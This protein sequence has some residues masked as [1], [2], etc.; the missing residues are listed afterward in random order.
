MWVRLVSFIVLGAET[1]GSEPEE[2][3]EA[4]RSLISRGLIPLGRLERFGKQQ[5][6]GKA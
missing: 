6:G 3:K 1:Q 4:K 2:G 5:R